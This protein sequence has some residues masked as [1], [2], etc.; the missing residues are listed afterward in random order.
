MR[1]TSPRRKASR[2]RRLRRQSHQHALPARKTQKFKMQDR[3]REVRRQTVRSQATASARSRKLERLDGCVCIAVECNELYHALDLFDLAFF[4]VVKTGRRPRLRSLWGPSV[5]KVT[6]L[7]SRYR[8]SP[9]AVCLSPFSVAS[10]S[11]VSNE[12]GCNAKVVSCGQ[13][14][15]VGIVN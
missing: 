13:P 11:K 15:E 14:S 9:T 4:P 3:L 7:R 6:L 1:R 8:R 2:N 5:K 12:I 10:R